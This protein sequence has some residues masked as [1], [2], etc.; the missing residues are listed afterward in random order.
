MQLV[1]ASTVIDTPLVHSPYERAVGLYCIQCK[2]KI[3]Q[4]TTLLRSYGAIQVFLT[5]DKYNIWSLFDFEK[6]GH[7]NMMMK[8]LYKEFTRT[9]IKDSTLYVVL[10]IRKSLESKTGGLATEVD[11]LIA[12]GKYGKGY[13]PALLNII[14]L[15]LFGPRTK[16]SIATI[17]KISIKHTERCL[18]I[19]KQRDT[20]RPVR[21]EGRA[22]VYDLNKEKFQSFFGYLR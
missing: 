4:V 21:K 20:I 19:L 2:E 8:K 5:N 14:R 17:L 9:V 16:R 3:E 22:D 11:I 6:V 15:L 10:E 12:D 1:S 13:W 7:F 18:R